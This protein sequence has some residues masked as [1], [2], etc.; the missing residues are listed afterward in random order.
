MKACFANALQMWAYDVSNTPRASLPSQT[1]TS[2][3][4]VAVSARWVENS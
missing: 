4:G 3:L 1:L 2:K